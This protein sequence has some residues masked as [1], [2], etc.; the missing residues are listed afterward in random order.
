LSRSL[1]KS[2]FASLSALLLLP[3]QPEDEREPGKQSS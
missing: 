3:T 2:T 1:S